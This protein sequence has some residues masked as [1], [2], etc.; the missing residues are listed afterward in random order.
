MS[1]QQEQTQELDLGLEA[2]TP[3]I[4]EIDYEAALSQTK[5]DFQRLAKLLGIKPTGS[6]Q[7]EVESDLLSKQQALEKELKETLVPK[8][9]A[10]LQSALSKTSNSPTIKP[11]VS[12]N[13][14]TTEDSRKTRA[15]RGY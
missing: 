8:I 5:P 15:W 7:Q 14:N 9:T 13:S 6:T 1:E 3:P 2:I 12:L 4:P 10:T 11:G